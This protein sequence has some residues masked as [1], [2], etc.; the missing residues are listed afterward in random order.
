MHDLGMLGTEGPASITIGI[1]PNGKNQ[2]E[3]NEF[4]N[5]QNFEGEDGGYR[6][7]KSKKSMFDVEQEQAE[8]HA[9]GTNLIQ[10]KYDTEP[11]S[12]SQRNSHNRDPSYPGASNMYPS[13]KRDTNP[14]LNTLEYSSQLQQKMPQSSYNTK[15]H[16][17]KH[18]TGIAFYKRD[19]EYNQVQQYLAQRRLRFIKEMARQQRGS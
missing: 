4:G 5:Q 12:Q 11:Q 8:G 15:R 7:Q 13:A 1:S 9:I 2:M 18:L 16:P 19:L 17:R 14:A 6:I 3:R 10:K